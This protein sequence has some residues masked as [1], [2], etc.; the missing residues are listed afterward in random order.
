MTASRDHDAAGVPI[1]AMQKD[2]HRWPDGAAAMIQVRSR[3]TM[4][5]FRTV[6]RATDCRT[7]LQQSAGLLRRHTPAMFATGD[8]KTLVAIKESPT[9]CAASPTSEYLR[10]S[11]HPFLR[12]R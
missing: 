3:E 12:R 7:W 1:A 10:R 9:M 5:H 4:T 8:E 6:A 2:R 11:L